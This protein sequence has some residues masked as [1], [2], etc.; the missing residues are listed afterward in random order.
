MITKVQ[1]Q[2][3]GDGFDNKSGGGPVVGFP[4]TGLFVGLDA[5][6]R[7]PRGST[8]VCGDTLNPENK[9]APKLPLE[10]SG[11]ARRATTSTQPVSMVFEAVTRV[12]HN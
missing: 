10:A 5:C 3:V 4:L 9:K 6:I 1:A 12:Q 8:I 11:E 7:F 2:V